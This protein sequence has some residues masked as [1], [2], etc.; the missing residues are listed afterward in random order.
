[1]RDFDLQKL[2]DPTFFSENTIPPH[3]DGEYFD[4]S[5]NEKINARLNGDHLRDDDYYGNTRFRQMLN[6]IW[7]IQVANNIGSLPEGFGSPDFDCRGWDEIRVP[8]HIQ[9]EGFGGVPHYTNVSYP[10]DGHED[11]KQGQ[12]P[13]IYNPAAAYVKYFEVPERF[14]G[15][16]LFISFRGVESNIILFLNGHYIGYSEDTFTPSDFELTDFLTEGENKLAAIVTKWSSGSWL[17][18]QD[19]YRFSGIFRDV[20]LYTKPAIH[21]DDVAV[22]T[23]L[24]DDFKK[25]ILKIDLELTAPGKVT[26]ELVE[27]SRDSVTPLPFEVD[28]IPQAPCI[29]AFKT[30]ASKTSSFSGKKAK[31]ELNIHEPELWSAEKPNLY[32]LLLTVFDKEDICN[33]VIPLQVGFRVFGLQDGIMKLNGKRIVFNG[34][35]RHEFSSLTGRAI[36]F[37]ETRRDL[38]NMK[39]NNINAVRTCHYPDNS[40]VYDLADNLG[41]YIIDETNME[42]HGTWSYGKMTDEQLAEVVPRD[43]PAWR[44]A[45][46]FRVNNMFQ[47][48]KNHA[49]ILIWSCGNES[50]GGRNIKL[51]HDLFHKLD[52]TRLVHY[53]GIVHDRRFND[54]SDMESQMYPKVWDI[55]NFLKNNPD[56]PFVCCEYSHAMGNSCGGMHKYTDLAAR[57]PRF[58]G[59]FIWDYIDQSIT[60]TDRFGKEFEAY[61]GDFGERP[62]DYNFS[63]NGIA[64]GDRGRE[65][66]PKMAEV[67]Y[68]YQNIKLSFN[69]Y[70]FT[71]MNR[72]L[73]TNTNEYDW[74]IILLKNGR[75]IK[76]IKTKIDVPPLTEKTFPLPKELMGESECYGDDNVNSGFDIE[77][78]FVRSIN[79]EYSVII[80][81]RLNYSTLFA[82]KDYEIGYGQGLPGIF[83]GKADIIPI[84][85]DSHFNL[86]AS[87]ADTPGSQDPL[88]SYSVP[89]RVSHGKGNLGI[90]GNDFEIQFCGLGLTSY[91]KCGREL[92]EGF[93]APSFWRAPTDNDRG[94]RMPMRCSQWK[95]ADMYAAVTGF[96]VNEV[97]GRILVTYTYSFP[98]TPAEN[99]TV[100]YFVD[101][102]GR[103]DVEISTGAGKKLGSMPVFGMRF[104]FN[105][106]FDRFTWYGYGPGESYSDRSHGNPL[107]IHKAKVA[108]QLSRYLVPQECGNKIGV[109]NA[110]V[111]DA[112]GRGI[113]F[114]S[115]PDVKG[116]GRYVDKEL[117]KEL[118]GTFEFQALPCSTHEL[119]NAMH[120]TELPPAHFTHVRIALAQLGI[121]GDD[122]WGA[123]THQEYYIDVKKPLAFRFSMKAI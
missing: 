17:E 82:S 110:K 27:I 9:M 91:K 50:N 2:S 74:E 88:L 70:K 86:Q 24:S 39:R 16:P 55:E 61:G 92:M 87:G 77:T 119:E 19:F 101:Y 111:T 13:V 72:N 56:K 69:K 4:I 32:G 54:T 105:A 107:G 102:D 53:E 37:A 79:V 95:L 6:G 29:P 22:K 41:L 36:T 31:L 73:F 71:V 7:K 21:A 14:L 106:D 34:V 116:S 109:R 51:M 62:S 43:N 113:L 58:Q 38:I 75:P 3:Y 45:V 12:I 97:M 52:D 85:L 112:K 46:L 117:S 68:N 100:K 8:A 66:S 115:C 120:S 123:P 60:T 65:S 122:S 30:V 99:C 44:D 42:T 28:E 93:P 11:I 57:E 40:F 104:K 35:N 59:G 64:Y 121:G 63:G 26:A 48:D 108:D 10:W 23:L 15:E 81:F 90:R 114:T 49:S 78:D 47:R 67:K 118:S 5:E 98:T 76:K 33:E 80:K 89:Y 83:T 103:I 1:M 84:D 94:N 18:D 25:G 20:F 96:T